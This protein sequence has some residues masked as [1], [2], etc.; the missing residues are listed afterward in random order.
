MTEK[1]NPNGQ[2][3]SWCSDVLARMKS[4]SEIRA[5]LKE[6][7][8]SNSPELVQNLL[9]YVI[10]TNHNDLVAHDKMC[11]RI[12]GHQPLYRCNK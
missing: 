8:S 3:A 1:N 7:V 11:S 6:I 12:N 2:P 5:D 4:P 10:R 9:D